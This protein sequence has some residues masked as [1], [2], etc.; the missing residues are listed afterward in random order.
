MKQM[1]KVH[2]LVCI[3]LYL[4][5]QVTT[6][7]HKDKA[8]E[9]SP[10]D[11]TQQGAGQVTLPGI[12]GKIVYHS[13]NSYGDKA[14]MFIYDFSAD[15]LTE[16]SRGWN[17]YDPINAHFSPDG[18]KIV[19]MGEAVRD[20]KW[21][22]YLWTV[23]ASGL[24]VNLTAGDG[25]RD[26]DPKFSSDGQ[27]ICF[28]QTP[29]G[30]DGNVKI[31]DLTGNII[32]GV[33]NNT[34]ES[35]MPYFSTDGTALVYARGS[36]STSDIYRVN[37]DGTLDHALVNVSN[38]QEYYPIVLDATSFLYARW[39][40]AA[41]HHDQ[42]YRGSFDGSV[43][44]RLPFNESTADFSDAFPCG[45]DYVILSC[46]KSGGSGAYD[47]YIADVTT[48]DMWSLNEYNAAINTS[49]NELGVSY[50]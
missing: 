14:K 41:D 1:F 31:M 47:L 2:P 11:T 27:S 21:D 37:I 44:V 25:C 42:V 48:G 34:I 13:Y 19:F 17:I 30:E 26:E 3:A 23:G 9:P 8:A 29:S 35:G 45:S 4:S 49:M 39:Y 12:K 40:S 36:G 38:V 15:Q 18:T 22:I 28:K 50:H 46:D 10:S 32:A 24:P 7:C 6:G 33:T 5:L 43:P 16:I 20:G